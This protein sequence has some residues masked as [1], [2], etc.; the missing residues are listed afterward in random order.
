MLRNKQ[1][2]GLNNLA[3]MA[4]T[5]MQLSADGKT[6]TL[7]RADGEEFTFVTRSDDGTNGETGDKGAT[8][9]QGESAYDMAKRLALT[10]ATTSSAWLTSLKGSKGPNGADGKPGAT[11]SA[12]ADGS[13][14]S[15]TIG[16]TS[17]LAAGSAPTL[18]ISQSGTNYVLNFG[19]PNGENGTAASNGTKP[20]LKIGT[21]TMGTT[22]GGDA[23]ASLAQSGS[24]YFLNMIIPKGSKGTDATASSGA[25]KNGY[26]P[27]IV[28]NVN[29]ISH[30]SEP[31]VSYSGNQST[32]GSD[33]TRTVTLNIPRGE[34]GDTGDKGAQGSDG[35]VDTASPYMVHQ[36]SSFALALSGVGL[37][38][39]LG[40]DSWYFGNHEAN[41]VMWVGFSFRTNSHNYQNIWPL[42]APGY[43]ISSPHWSA[44]FK[45]SN[46]AFGNTDRDWVELI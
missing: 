37:S 42:G 26:A 1:I 23:A 21:V 44:R 2:E 38:S 19:I 5:N 20:T 35:S 8:G 14:P 22:N 25:G 16:T 6:V 15:F 43:T 30:G 34:T 41:R 36:S 39:I 18:E 27:Q 7:T 13:V 46:D 12:G 4:I 3:N 17:W 28:F 9:A 29:Y 45:S 24:T 11:G 32:T 10:N 31:S 40:D 33:W